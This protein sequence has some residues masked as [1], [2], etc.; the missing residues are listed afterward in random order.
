MKI[1]ISL[2]P[3]PTNRG[4]A[5]GFC[6]LAVMGGYETKGMVEVLESAG[7]FM[8]GGTA[9]GGDSRACFSLSLV[10]KHDRPLGRMQS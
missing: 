9:A 1:S 3:K 7:G 10:V 8:A 2:Y 6:N 4:I 5:R